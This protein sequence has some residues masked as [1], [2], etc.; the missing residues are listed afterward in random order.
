MA[1]REDCFL[2]QFRLRGFGD[3]EVDNLGYSHAIVDRDQ[4]VR[5]FE[6]AMDDALLVGMLDGLADLREQIES[7]ARGKILLVAVVRDLY[8]AN[9]FHHEVRKAGRQMRSCEPGM[10]I[11]RASCRERV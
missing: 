11:G 8:A 9:E 2:C 1:A 10:Q 3:A 7:L 6:V 4:N 5:G